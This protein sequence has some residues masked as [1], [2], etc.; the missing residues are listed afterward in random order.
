MI[1]AMMARSAY[2]LLSCTL[3]ILSC[4]G[5]ASSVAGVEAES[6]SAKAELLDSF[7]APHHRLAISEESLGSAWEIALAQNH[8]I[9]SSEQRQ[10]AALDQVAETRAKRLP[11]LTLSANYLSLDN[12]PTI[13]ATFAESDFAFSYWEKNALYYSVYSSIPLYSS[14]LIQESIAAAR[15]QAEAARLD[16]GSERQNLKMAVATA[17]IDILRANHGLLLAQSHV[18]SI[19]KHHTDV[20]NLKNKGLVSGGDLLSASVTLA[21]ARQALTRAR[22]LL[23]LAYAAYNQLLGRDLSVMHNLREPDTRLPGG[24]LDELTLRA[25]QQ[26]EEL[27]ALRKR[28]N[29]LRHSAASVKAETRPQVLL[30]GGYAY[31]EN[32]NQLYEGVWF[33]NVGMV[34]KL[35][36]GGGTAHRSSNLSRQAN[37][38][39]AQHDNLGALVQLQVRQAW[40]KVT[41]TQERIKVTQG[42]VAQADEYLKVAGNRYREGISTHTEV[43]DAETLRVKAEANHANARYDS[44]MARLQLQRAIGEL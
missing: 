39:K 9:K 18:A 6:S 28:A 33:A 37:A 12:P 22:N 34:W 31:Q 23:E 2:L 20:S 11:D 43:L 41:E 42:S 5:A 27:V 25:I 26:R 14:G 3:M 36:D 21:D 44:L 8:L 40:L 35:M 10:F 17:Y 15:A 16:T 29:A 24:D 38:L 4:V 13:Q 32:K 7:D 30:G 1:F 19:D